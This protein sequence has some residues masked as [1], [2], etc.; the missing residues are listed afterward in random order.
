[1]D[2][3]E[4][5]LRL[6]EGVGGPALWK[7]RKETAFRTTKSI[8]K[9]G[10]MMMLREDLAGDT[11]NEVRAIGALLQMAGE[12]G[13]ASSRML[14]GNEHYAG[15][16]LLRQIVEVEY[17]TWTFKEG[18]ESPKGW[19]ESSFDER[20]RAFSPKQ[21]RSNSKGRFL[22]KD[23]QDHCEQGGHPV[24]RGIELLGGRA[25]EQAQLLQV[26]LLMHCW[27]TWDQVCEWLRNHDAASEIGFPSYGADISR[28]LF[29]W[30]K[31]DP[32]YRL[33]VE[34]KPEANEAE[35]A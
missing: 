33:A 30:G 21:L 14:S 9:V 19:L 31:R 11:G 24:P 20:M 32:L 12:L 10:L 29:E 3:S 26:D 1:M 7:L 5:Q 18:Y 22:F 16:A 25:R 4:F 35:A 28:Q 15:A 13:F 6:R 2:D 34:V 17:L 8:A 27:R 23:Y